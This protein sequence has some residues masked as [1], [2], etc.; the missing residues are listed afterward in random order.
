MSAFADGVVHLSMA[1]LALG[2][3]LLVLGIGVSVFAVALSFVRDE[4]KHG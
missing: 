2:A 3:G 1:M 4:W